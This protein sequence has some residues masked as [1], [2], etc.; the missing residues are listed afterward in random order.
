MLGGDLPI[1]RSAAE[2]TFIF[3]LV[4]KQKTITGYGVWLGFV[5]K[6]DNKFYWIDDTPLKGSY[7]RWGQG[8]PNN[9]REKCGNIFGKGTKEGKW[10]DFP[11]SWIDIK[12]APSI[13]CQ[14]KAN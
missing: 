14:K 9:V 8:E 4:K 5:R 10:N 11:C 12:S 6:A 3:D 2:N 7:A 13:L 1:I